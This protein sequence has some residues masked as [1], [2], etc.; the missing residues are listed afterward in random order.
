MIASFPFANVIQ[1][2]GSV[3]WFILLT[4]IRWIEI[5]P[6]DSV[7]HLLNNPGQIDILAPGSICELA[8]ITYS[9]EQPNT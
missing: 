3:A 4:I 7:I 9:R 6:V 2:S 8:R 1:W 5:Y